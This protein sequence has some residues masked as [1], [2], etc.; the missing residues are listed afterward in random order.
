MKD[1]FVNEYTYKKFLD[2]NKE[3]EFDF[4]FNQAIE[5]TKRLFGS[6]YPIYIDGK[7]IYL[8]NKLKETSPIDHNIII[9]YFSK[10]TR[11][12]AKQ[13]ITAAKKAFEI[14][15]N[16]NYKKRI[17]IFKK[18]AEAF[19]KQ[20][21][22]L[23]A[24]LSFE[25]AK[26]RYESIGEVDEAIDF[27]NYYINE[28]TLNK[29]FARKTS[30]EAAKKIVELNFQGAPAEAENVSI[31]LKPYGVFGIISP[32]NF[33]LSISIGMSVG[34]LI[35][36]N[37]VVFKPST[38]N[39]TL[40]ISVKIYKIF[41]E[42]GIPDGVF[43]VI[44]GPGS[45]I[46]EEFI[47]NNDINGIAFTGS[48][49]VGLNMIKKVYDEEKQK[50]FVVEMGGKNPAIVSKHANLD[51][52]INGVATAAFGFVGQKC[53]ALSR[54][55]VHESIKELFV[56]K[57]IDKL[58]L[59]KI[60]N[61]LEKNIFIGA[62]ISEKAYNKF[63]EII[64]KAKQTGR[65]LYGGNTI[66]IGLDGFYVEPTLIEVLHDNELIHNEL[67]LPILTIEAFKEFDDAIRLANDTEYGLTSGLYS[68]NKTEIKQFSNEIKSGV[69]YINRRIS[70]TTGAVVGLHTFVGW[71]NSGLT[72]KGSG[73]KYYLQQFMK[74]QSI[75]I[76]K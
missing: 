2:L 35:T 1:K 21:F 18:I 5:Q 8:E 67:F 20:K 57:L 38:D 63:I 36:G 56:S 13:A 28:I 30:S 45:E 51:K 75:S 12:N 4:L 71:K 74:E 65:I 58:R 10:A 66:K 26:S 11:E 47:E 76:T 32:F 37:T 62:L 69:V 46:G 54:L 48:R 53:S 41:K 61:P 72:G 31:L 44:S 50:V 40:L 9:G 14:W 23:A 19:S 64:K 68:Q 52:A 73:S 34:A 55:Y 43:N 16:I 6:E 29:G 17:E 3:E 33:P 42:N 70:A 39:R 25:N 22:E 49:S 60:G 59:M 24:I 27:I 7:E 15:S